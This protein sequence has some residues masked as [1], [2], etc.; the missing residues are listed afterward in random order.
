MRTAL[1]VLIG[2]F[3]GFLAGLLLAGLV[4]A[5]ARSAAGAPIDPYVLR[6][7]P[8]GLAPVGAATGA[9]VLWLRP[10]VG[11]RAT[12]ADRASPRAAGSDAE[13]CGCAVR[14]R[15]DVTLPG[16]SA[17]DDG[18]P[19]VP[20]LRQVADSDVAAPYTTAPAAAA[21][22]G[23][24]APLLSGAPAHR[25]TRTV[26]APCPSAPLEPSTRLLTTRDAPICL[27]TDCPRAPERTS[28]VAHTRSRGTTCCQFREKTRSSP[29]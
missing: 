15:L 8:L 2:L 16:V 24:E 1:T 14:P 22:D 12:G 29:S 28:V 20:C 10:R 4:D 7:L 23:R 27:P 19:G 5:V 6:Y 17:A 26:P 9:V 21:H 11:R 18:H 3:V 13:A 25:G